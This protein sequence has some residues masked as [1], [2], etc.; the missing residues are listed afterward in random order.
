[1]SNNPDISAAP[2]G[3]GPVQQTAQDLSF[4]DLVA[5]KVAKR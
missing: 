1:M 2:L 4:K 3:T 5:G